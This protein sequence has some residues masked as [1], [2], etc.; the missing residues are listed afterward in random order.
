MHEGH[1]RG[2]GTQGSLRTAALNRWKAPELTNKSFSG[3]IFFLNNKPSE[4]HKETNSS[5]CKIFSAQT[6]SFPL[7]IIYRYHSQNSQNHCYKCVE[8]LV[9]HCFKA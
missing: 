9:K 5:S 3:I 8:E 4:V 2:T 7:K 6:H 1:A